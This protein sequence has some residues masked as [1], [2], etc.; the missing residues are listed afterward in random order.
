MEEATEAKSG[1]KPTYP[2]ARGLAKSALWLGFYSPVPAATPAPL[3]K[4]KSMA[5]TSSPGSACPCLNLGCQLWTAGP[6]AAWGTGLCLGLQNVLQICAQELPC[7]RGLFNTGSP[8]RPGQLCFIL[9]PSSHVTCSCSVSRV[10]CL[11]PRQPGSGT[12][13][14]LWFVQSLPSARSSPRVNA[15]PAWFLSK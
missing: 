1:E 6:P 13:G 7:W 2:L 4:F 15:E 11:C 10:V 9:A 14:F 5:L 12:R 8:C 3:P